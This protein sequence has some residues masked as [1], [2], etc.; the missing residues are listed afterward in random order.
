MYIISQCPFNVGNVSLFM[1]LHGCVVTCGS[2]A[3]KQTHTNEQ[4]TSIFAH[5]ID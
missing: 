2:C 1:R 3:T 4:R 5:E